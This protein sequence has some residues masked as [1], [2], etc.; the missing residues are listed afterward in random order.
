M[1]SVEIPKVL[2]DLS[3]QSDAAKLLQDYFTSKRRNGAP[4][5]SGSRFEFLSP[6]WREGTQSFAITAEDIVAVQCLGVEFTG[7]QVI[8][9]LEEKKRD[10]SE[11]LKMPGMEPD[12]VLWADDQADVEA[13]GSPGNQLWD[14]L[15]SPTNNGIGAT[16]AS[17]LMTRKRPSVFPVYDKWVAEALGRKNANGY[18]T[19]YR[20]LILE[21]LDGEPL[22]RHLQQLADALDL[23]AE[24]TPLRVSDVILWYSTNPLLEDR[25]KLITKAG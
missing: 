16:K 2:Q 8:E 11:L 1:A 14:L 10:I 20:N 22:H 19:Y 4:R 3:A 15:K 17:K 23:P 12:A 25:R 24:V 7:D 9:I 21:P 5:F 13:K 6:S 18:W